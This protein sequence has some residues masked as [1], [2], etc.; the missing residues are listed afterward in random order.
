MKLQIKDVVCHQGR[1]WIVQGVLTYKLGG[2]TLPLARV[3]DGSDVRFVEPLLDDLDDRVLLL[4]EVT[5]LETS[6]PPAPTLSYG[7]KTYVPRFSGTATVVVDGRV[8]ERTS[9]SCEV[10]RYRAAGDLFLQIEKWPDRVVV[11]AGESVHKG[12]IDVLPG[13]SS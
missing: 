3:V 7:G 12:M 10:W 2:R 5:D 6:T 13:S 4:A 9:G 8:P 11:L 1:D